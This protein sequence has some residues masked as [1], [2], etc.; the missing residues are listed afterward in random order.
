MGNPLIAARDAFAARLPERRVVVN[1]RD[2]GVIDT[3]SGRPGDA[4]PVLLLLPGTLGRADIF[5]HQIADLAE[6]GAESGAASGAEARILSVSYPGSGGV[7]DWI[8]DLTALLDRLGIARVAVLGSSLGGYV[9]QALAAASPDRVSHLFAANTLASTDGIALRPPYSLDLWREDIGVLR[10]GFAAAMQAWGQAHPE[11]GDL[12]AFLL[13]ESAS[14]IPDAEMRARLAA[15]KEAPALPPDP[16]PADQT[17]IIDAGDDPLLPAPIRQGVR[18]RFPHS[19]VFHF[20]TGGH[21]PY[22]L[23]PALYSG[24]LHARLGLG[25]LP[26]D[27]TDGVA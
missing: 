18:A 10:G 9:A 25:P 4:G 5:W 1:A 13:A 22:I 11:Q 20:A 23:R 6:S 27:W 3:A 26:R 2:W 21:F 14:R 15:L 12:V 8:G 19:A 17:T 16:R 24:L 7:A